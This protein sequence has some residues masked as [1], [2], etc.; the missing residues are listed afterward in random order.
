MKYRRA[1]RNMPSVQTPMGSMP[2]RCMPLHP[3]RIRILF[4]Q[5]RALRKTRFAAP[6]LSLSFQKFAADLYSSVV[7]F[8]SFLKICLSLYALCPP[9]RW[10]YSSA[11]ASSDIGICGRVLETWCG[12]FIISSCLLFMHDH[13]SFHQQTESC[14]S[15]SCFNVSPAIR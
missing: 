9:I 2:A 14:Q 10:L 5:C 3:L 12:R 4:R 7:M 11:V 1:Y 13:L 15:A 6:F 8:F